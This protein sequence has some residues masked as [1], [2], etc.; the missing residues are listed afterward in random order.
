MARAGRIEVQVVGDTASLSRA[1][2]Q[3]NR[4][5]DAFGRRL[6]MAGTA[7]GIAGVAIGGAFVT[8]GLKSV[9]AAADF[10]K[11]LNVM[12]SVSGATAT[13]M[14]AISKLALDLGKD[15]KLPGTSA[16][17][18]AEAMVELS[19]SGMSVNQI[20][21]AVRPT[22]V[23]S[24]AAQISNAR[25]AEITSNALNAFGLDA[26]RTAKIT[27]LL[28]NAAN[29]SSV[30]IEDA[31][32]S[33]KMAGAV[34]AGFQG[35]AVGS[36]Q[37]LKDLATA[38]GLLG[39]AGIKGSDAGTSLKQMLLQLTGPSD[40]SAKAMDQLAAAAGISN[41]AIA[42][43]ANIAFTATG[44]MRSLPQ[45][46]DIVT[47]ATENMTQK[48][49]AFY[50]T[51]VFGA[52]ASRAVIALMKQQGAGWDNMSKA[53]DKNGA[54]QDL[55]AAKMKGFRG[56]QEALSSTLDT[57]AITFGM[58]LL[59]VVTDFI[60]FLNT[61]AIP[62]AVKMAEAFDRN[63]PR[64]QA[65]IEDMWRSAKP[66]FEALITIIA[67]V[68][69]TVDK[70]W[71]LI[72]R[73][74]QALK[75][76]IQDAMKVVAALLRLPIDLLKGDWAKAWEDAKQIVT[77]TIDGIKTYLTNQVEN[78]KAI[79]LGIGKAAYNG[80]KEGITGI[81]AFIL[82][83]VLGA[84]KTMLTN[85]A[86]NVKTS[87]TSI[88]KAILNGVVAGVAGIAAAV[89]TVITSILTKFVE[90]HEN[91][92]G[93][94]LKLGGWLKD[95]IV[96]GVSGVALAVWG[97]VKEIPTFIIDKIEALGGW[98][99][100]IGVA[101]K[102]AVVDGLAG[103]GD[104][105]WDKIKQ[106]V[107]DIK[108]P[109]GIDIAKSILGKGGTGPWS[110]KDVIPAGVSGGGNFAASGAAGGPT[111][112]EASLHDEY[113]MARSMISNWADL[114]TY[115]PASLL[116]SGAPSDHAVYPAKAFDAGFSPATGWD[117]LS[118]R[119]FFMQMIGRPG[120]HYAIL[121]DKIWSAEQGLHQYFN[122]SDH[123]NH[124]HVSGYDR[125]GFLQPG[126]NLA[127]N[128]TGRPEPVGPARGGGPTINVTVNGA[129]GTKEEIA[130][131][132]VD[133][134]NRNQRIGGMR[135]AT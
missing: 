97:V 77:A 100:G 52:D 62:A 7:A 116:P 109:S 133:T 17:D 106:E 27:D 87:A 46:I 95:A 128:G 129:V 60:V 71:A 81:G 57:L 94:G 35:P 83:D 107:N 82:E 25:A 79:A 59:P 111:S 54:A 39:N 21:K 93:W 91:V 80:I 31:A 119:A 121:G 120:I 3:A 113:A 76:E 43:G 45:I 16:K 22:L 53:I 89:W 68:A 66:I 41:D 115:N 127:W 40:K 130:A 118:A 5:T 37:A 126:W 29:A 86:E 125:G 99:K 19:K 6:R 9:N 38:I 102:D 13:Q 48:Q 72:E 65:V 34:F 112:L 2:R 67:L 47:K 49:R 134:I 20:M 78:V 36:E 75:R 84:I 92:L 51:Q 23:L 32:D 122:A 88:G 44:K 103:I 58:R 96:D 114:G 55:A 124:V 8:I 14:K 69:S 24:A 26:S 1:F 117:N 73:N 104:A 108:G 63:W 123:A 15:I 33:M 28:A 131:T 4:D 42:K 11:S 85:Q 90:M 10:E 105:I 50:I 64:I 101:I 110:A 61:K 74:M 18:A 70:H 56:A 98:A 135:F 30:E 12:Q 132:I